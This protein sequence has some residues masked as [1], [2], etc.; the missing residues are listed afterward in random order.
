MRRYVL[1]VLFLCGGCADKSAIAR[2][3]EKDLLGKLLLPKT[4]MLTKTESKT[5]K[6]SGGDEQQVSLT[7][8]SAD[9]N[10]NMI[11]KQHV[12]FFPI[13]RDGKPDP[14]KIIL[15]L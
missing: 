5:L 2:E 3:C 7:Y 14:S 9:L 10:G 13:A 15:R 11:E 1:V 6:I 12:C 4:Y 8:K